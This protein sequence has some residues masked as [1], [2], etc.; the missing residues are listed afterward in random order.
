MHRLFTA[1]SMKQV[2]EQLH[3]ADVDSLYTAIGAGQVSAQ[4]VANQL[5]AM[6]GDQ[7]DAI[8]TLASR[9]PLSEIENSVPSTPR[10]PHRAPASW[11]RAALM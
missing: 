7:D 11:W 6:F 8:D 4:H 9:T 2:A 10:T 3:H 5:V 1:R